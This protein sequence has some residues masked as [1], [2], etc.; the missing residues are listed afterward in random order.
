MWPKLCITLTMRMWVLGIP[1][2]GMHA[3]VIG[4]ACFLSGLCCCTE[5]GCAWLV[6][7]SVVARLCEDCVVKSLMS[8]LAP[9]QVLKLPLTAICLPFMLCRQWQEYSRHAYES[10]YAAWAPSLQQAG[11]HVCCLKSV[12]GT[13]LAALLLQTMQ[14][15]WP[16]NS[17]TACNGCLWCKCCVCRFHICNFAPAVWRP[18]LGRG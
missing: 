12:A 17:L 18:G 2:T 4:C 7:E 9:P 5:R 11:L 1:H 3:E 15:A 16:V 13:A 6:V 10:Q 14:A 8:H